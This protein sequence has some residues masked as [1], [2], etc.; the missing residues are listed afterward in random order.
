MEE[1][2]SS[3]PG[4][5]AEELLSLSLATD[6][7]SATAESVASGH[8]GMLLSSVLS[9]ARLLCELFKVAARGGDGT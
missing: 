9:S 7:T 4:G 2:A 1:A 8:T 6:A 5:R 3:P